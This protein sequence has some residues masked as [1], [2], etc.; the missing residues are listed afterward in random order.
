MKSLTR[1]NL[2]EISGLLASTLVASVAVAQTSMGE[3][4]SPL[5][6]AQARF[7][8]QQDPNTRIVG[9]VDASYSNHPWQ[10]ALL[11][12]EDPVRARAQF[13]GGT[14]VGRDLVLTAAHCVDKVAK[15]EEI[16]VLVGTASLATG[17]RRMKV[18]QFG[19][20]EGFSRKTMDSDIAWIRVEVPPNESIGTPIPINTTPTLSL[21]LDLRVTGWG[22]TE[23][24]KSGTEQLKVVDLPVVTEAVC[25]APL[26]YG[27]RITVNM[28]CAGL[29]DGGK[30]SCQGD[31]G[32][33]GTA[34]IGG[35]RKLVGVVSWGD[36][37]ARE[38]KY[39]VY[40]NVARYLLWLQERAGLEV[41]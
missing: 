8:R 7:K 25:K 24:R 19:Y 21:P 14:V 38:N 2:T 28:L 18:S 40:T 3:M 4:Y 11:N 23:S 6:E 15:K 33:P 10:V 35:V 30:D 5:E 34:D 17:G 9:G 22:V 27:S 20:H 39:G 13:C 12:A 29:K 26:S 36:G 32:G 41:K 1:T 16:D 37:C 31:S